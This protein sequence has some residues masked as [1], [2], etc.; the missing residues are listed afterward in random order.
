MIRISRSH[1]SKVNVCTTVKKVKLRTTQRDS[2]IF[3]E[4]NALSRLS[5]R[6][7]VRY[8]TTWVETSEPES[9]AASSGSAS[10]TNTDEGDAMTSVPNSSRSN[11]TEEH[12]ASF[13]GRF[14][15]DLNDLDDLGGSGTQSSF[16]SIHFGGSASSEE[17]ASDSSGSTENSN[18]PFGN[19]FSKDSSADHIEFRSV[20]PKTPP[21]VAR[22]LYI[23]MVRQCQMKRLSVCSSNAGIRRASDAKGG[24]YSIIPSKVKF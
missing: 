17:K 11:S 24:S 16:P 22:T 23:Q 15:I 2:K 14:S 8:Y 3:R 13:N 5:H 21:L 10:E 9:T 7:I 18:D 4:V 19:L 1:Q 20:R 12:H 6:F